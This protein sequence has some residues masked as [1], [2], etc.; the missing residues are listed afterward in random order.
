MSDNNFMVENW[1]N[2][3]EGLVPFI[4]TYINGCE[5]WRRLKQCDALRELQ[6]KWKPSISNDV[7]SRRKTPE[8]SITT[9]NHEIHNKKLKGDKAFSY[10][11]NPSEKFMKLI[12]YTD[13][14]KI[15]MY[16]GVK[17]NYDTCIGKCN[18][19]SNQYIMTSKEELL[20]TIEKMVKEIKSTI[21]LVNRQLVMID[22]IKFEIHTINNYE[23]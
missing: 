13:E 19:V 10:A 20:I 17:M 23:I 3:P 12:R 11:L 15:N 9:Y 1:T 21:R 2:L 16:V 22:F 7:V 8:K 18:M 6:R 5:G 14:I 4:T